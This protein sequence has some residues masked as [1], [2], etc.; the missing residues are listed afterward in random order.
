MLGTTPKAR[1]LFRGTGAN[2]GLSQW[3]RAILRLSDRLAL[4]G[5]RMETLPVRPTPPTTEAMYAVV[6]G[7]VT[8]A[9]AGGSTA[10]ESGK[11]RPRLVGVEG[12]KKR[13][14]CS[15]EQG[16]R[17]VQTGSAGRQGH[18]PGNDRTTTSPR[19]DRCHLPLRRGSR[20][21]CW[22]RYRRRGASPRR[23]GAPCRHRPECGSRRLPRRP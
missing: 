21:R 22:C 1:P 23:R 3:L 12:R 14:L 5:W 2:R 11:T 13:D 6:S 17:A 18:P 10:R 19:R 16:S 15:L 8:S 7:N 9:R 4:Y 20:R